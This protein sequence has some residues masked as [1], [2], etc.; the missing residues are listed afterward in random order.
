M[1]WRRRSRSSSSRIAGED[2]WKYVGPD[3]RGVVLEVI[4]VESDAE[5]LLVI[6]VMPDDFRGENDD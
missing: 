3:D 4:A 2:G 5:T 6:H 1:S